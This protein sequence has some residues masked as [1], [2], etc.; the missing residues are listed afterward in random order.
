MGENGN[1]IGVTKQRNK[2]SKA[3]CC[4]TLNNARGVVEGRSRRGEKVVEWATKRGGA[5]TRWMEA[6]DRQ[7]A[8]HCQSGPPLSCVLCWCESFGVHL[9]I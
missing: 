6:E 8:G 4:W 1:P 2:I 3:V 9:Q 5:S 7:E